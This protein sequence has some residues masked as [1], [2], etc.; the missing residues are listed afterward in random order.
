MSGRPK[1]E[2]LQEAHMRSQ[3]WLSRLEHY[4]RQGLTA[5]S[6]YEEAA[7]KAE[8]WMLRHAA[9]SAKQDA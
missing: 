1:H 3:R 7:R 9:L 5:G 6:E 4:E 8:Y 2:K